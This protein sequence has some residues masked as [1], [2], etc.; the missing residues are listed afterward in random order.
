MMV[1]P[2]PATTLVKKVAAKGK[3]PV[4]QMTR[5][6]TH[7]VTQVPSPLP[8][9]VKAPR[10]YLGVARP[11][12]ALRLPLFKESIPSGSGEIGADMPVPLGE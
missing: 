6:C 12:A 5:P 2:T 8:G 4:C 7:K 11:S 3:A 1:P 9:V 10:P